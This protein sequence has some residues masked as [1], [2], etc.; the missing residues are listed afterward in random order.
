MRFLSV[1]VFALCACL[2]GASAEAKDKNQVLKASD[3]IGMKVEDTQGKKLGSIK[4]LVLDNDGE[5]QYAVLDFGGFLGI[6]DKYFAVPWDALDV[7]KD[8]GR[9][10]LDVTKKDLKQAPGFDKNHWPDFSDR[11]ESVTIYEFY[12]VPTPE[13][14]N[15]KR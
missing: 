8:K 6:G 7:G 3:V 11:K 13:D 9:L 14:E 2:I 15:L 4:D 12:G 1:A 5:I 10:A